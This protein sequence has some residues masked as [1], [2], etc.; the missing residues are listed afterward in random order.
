MYFQ[1]IKKKSENR[2]VRQKAACG[3]II[4][5]NTFAMSA[6]NCFKKCTCVTYTDDDDEECKPNCVT[7][8]ADNYTL[9]TGNK[10]VNESEM[11]TKLEQVYIHPEHKF[12]DTKH[13]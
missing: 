1:T 3:A 7:Y 8:G 9:Y 6:A 10:Y 2:F 11:I 12:V 13:K 4:L 5:S